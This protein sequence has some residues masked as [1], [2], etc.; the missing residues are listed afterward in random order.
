MAKSKSAKQLVMEQRTLSPDEIEKM[1]I[2]CAWD[3]CDQSMSS[4]EMTPPD[5]SDTYDYNLHLL[6]SRKTV[7]STVEFDDRS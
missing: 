4:T 7:R 5:R 2:A 3:E 6:P 1:R